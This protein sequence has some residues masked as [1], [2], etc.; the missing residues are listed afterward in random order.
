MKSRLTE[1]HRSSKVETSREFAQ[2]LNE[3]PYL[4]MS[5]AVSRLFDELFKSEEQL[6]NY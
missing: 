2:I 5:R 6:A 1:K 4:N 3:A